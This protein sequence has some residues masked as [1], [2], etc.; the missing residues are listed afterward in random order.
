MQRVIEL[1]TQSQSQSA[2]YIGSTALSGSSI[3][4]L[5]LGENHTQIA[6][7]GLLLGGIIGL[8]GLVFQYRIYKAKK[9]YY[10]AKTSFEMRRKK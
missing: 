2:T 1:T 7:C 10:D 5:W 3:L 4:W 9:R 8:A 6:S